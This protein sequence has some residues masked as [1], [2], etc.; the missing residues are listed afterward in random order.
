MITREIPVDYHKRR[1]RKKKANESLTQIRATGLILDQSRT[2]YKIRCV[3]HS[4]GMLNPS[5]P[6]IGFGN[7]LASDWLW[8]WSVYFGPIRSRRTFQKILGIVHSVLKK[9]LICQNKT[10]NANLMQRRLPLKSF[11][12]LLFRDHEDLRVLQEIVDLMAPRLV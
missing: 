7:I 12:L 3:V 8:K 6:L 1:K 2:F 11:L 5:S 4:V 10:K 9:R